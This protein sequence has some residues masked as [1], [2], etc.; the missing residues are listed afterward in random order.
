MTSPREQARP[1]ARGGLRPRLLPGLK[2]PGLNRSSGGCQ[3]TRSRNW[4]RAY[5]AGRTLNELA[6]EF[7][8]HRRTVAAHLE[9]NGIPR[10]AQVSKLSHVQ[11]LEAIH[12]YASGSSLVRLGEHFDVN[13]ETVR[14]ALLQAGIA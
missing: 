2:A 13:A 6:V 1:R 5:K 4:S 12:L 14:R 11:V 7:Q 3:P 9:R 10:R 8:I